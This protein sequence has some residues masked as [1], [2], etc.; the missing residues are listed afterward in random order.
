MSGESK[1]H[2]EAKH[3]LHPLFASISRSCVVHRR[4]NR[5]QGTS[6]HSWLSPGSYLCNPRSD[7]AERGTGSDCHLHRRQLDRQRLP[8]WWSEPIQRTFNLLPP[9]QLQRQDLLVH[10]HRVC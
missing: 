1:N 4:S 8:E 9:S 6:R 7:L 2:V 5:T 10:D 3:V